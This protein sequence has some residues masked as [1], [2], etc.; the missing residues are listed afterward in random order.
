MNKIKSYD[1]ISM[2]KSFYD[3]PLTLTNEWIDIMLDTNIADENQKQKRILF[4]HFGFCYRDLSN[5]DFTKVDKEHLLKVPFNS[6]TIFPI[7]EKMPKGF[8]P[9]E[10]IAFAKNPFMGIKELHKRGVN[11]EGICVAT[12]DFGFQ[13]E[14]HIEFANANIEI[15]D[16]FKDTGYHFHATGVLANLCGE[17]IGF[18]PKVRVLHYNTYQGYGE[19]VDK[20]T[21][22]ILK[23]ILKR[24]KDGEKIRAVNISAPLLRN[25]KLQSLI[26]DQ[27]SWQ[28]LR[29]EQVVPFMNVIEELKLLGCEV[30]S[31]ERFSK[32]FSCS[33]INFH[34]SEVVQPDWISFKSYSDKM[35][36]ISGGKVIPEFLSKEGY[37]YEPNGSVSWSIPQAVGLYALVLQI[38]SN[39][40][41]DEFVKICKDSSKVNGNNVRIIN[42]QKLINNVTA[43]NYINQKN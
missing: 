33:K 41:W 29:D 19:E 37:K 22:T 15:V 2:V 7:V 21:L 4:T 25:K 5:Y 40:T 43:L 6:S 10:I 36:F 14:K 38:N 31:S 39:V 9:L 16:L 34:T 23:D 24:I 30:I 11:G 18:A 13:D 12:I 32:D 3:I 28:K 42:V 26:S 35:T 17:N 8:Y 27:E 1:Y 20:A